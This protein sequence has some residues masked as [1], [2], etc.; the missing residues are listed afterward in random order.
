[1]ATPVITQEYNDPFLRIHQ[2]SSPAD[3]GGEAV[4]SYLL[5]FATCLVVLDLPLLDSVAREIRD[6]ADELNKPIL[7]VVLSHAHPDHWFGLYRFKDIAS[8]ATAKTIAEIR[9]QG[10]NYLAFKQ[11]QS[12]PPYN[13]PQEAIIPLTSFEGGDETIDGVH[14][15]WRK[16]SNVEYLDGLYLEIANH[17]I[18]I[19][20]DLVYNHVH[21]YLGQKDEQGQLCISNWIAILTTLKAGH[22]RDIF[23]GHGAKGG[24]DLLDNSIT[25]LKALLPIVTATGANEAQYRQ[26]LKDH[27]A[28]FG[29]MEMVDISAYFLFHQ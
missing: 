22:F 27:F 13:L 18:L 23:P 15:A 28:D 3:G 24:M 26:F 29:V 19:A 11:S 2:F 25:Y 14:L 1:M 7:K 8:V 12:T 10:A 6:F 5:E 9:D 4:N 16:A 17:N 21:H 20:G